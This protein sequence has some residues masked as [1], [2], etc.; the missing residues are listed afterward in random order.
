MSVVRL[1]SDSGSI[2]VLFYIL[3]QLRILSLVTTLEQKRG[4]FW[5]QRERLS[6]HPT[7]S[8]KLLSLQRIY[9][10]ELAKDPIQ[11]PMLQKTFACL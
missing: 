8:F 5:V 11:Y 6:I 9:M 10:E 3:C 7:L 4:G 2:R 1:S